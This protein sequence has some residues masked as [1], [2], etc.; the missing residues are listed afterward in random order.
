VKGIKDPMTERTYRQR[1]GGEI[2][3]LHGRYSERRRQGDGNLDEASVSEKEK[4]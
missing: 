1:F 2:H 4:V 3:D